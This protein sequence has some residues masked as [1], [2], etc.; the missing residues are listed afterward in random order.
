MY[1]N[2]MMYGAISALVGV[3]AG[4][5]GAHG[6]R[7]HL[8]AD[9]LAVYETAVRYELIHAVALLFVGLAAARWPQ[10]HW[11][12]S[13]WLFVAGTILFSGSLFALSLTGVRWPGVITP[14]GGACF[15]AGWALAAVA[16]ARS[17]R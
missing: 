15:L 16:S 8:S 17:M 10:A 7:G 5:F 1:R 6:L 12:R 4:A 3:A 2:F 13:G 11:E 14:F 9:L